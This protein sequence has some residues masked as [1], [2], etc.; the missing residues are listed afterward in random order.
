LADVAS[1]GF[2]VDSS[3][4]NTA[5]TALGKLAASAKPAEA[6]VKQLGGTHAAGISFMR[7]H[8]AEIHANSNAI[9]LNR[10]QVLEL[11]H[12]VRAAFDSLAS[13]ASPFRVLAQQG[14]EL[15]QALTSGQG[16]VAGSLK[17]VGNALTSMFTVSRI[18]SGGLVGIATAGYAAW[19]AWDDKVRALTQSMNGLGRA[20]GLS[21]GAVMAMAQGGR[22][23]SVSQSMSSAG[24]YIGAGIDGQTT[25]RLMG[26]T[27]QYAHAFGLSTSD[28]TTELSKAFADPAKGLEELA[29][30]FGPLGAETD[31][32]VKRMAALGDLEGARTKLYSAYSVELEKTKDASG[33]LAKAMES[34]AKIASNAWARLG[35]AGAPQTPDEQVRMALHQLKDANKTFGELGNAN[36]GSGFAMPGIKGGLGG[37][38][39]FDMQSQIEQMAAQTLASAKPDTS[40]AD[41]SYF[42]TLGEVFSKISAGLREDAA[43]VEDAAKKRKSY[44]DLQIKEVNDNAKIGASAILARTAADRLAVDQ[45]RIRVAAIY[46]TSKANTA[47]A[48][49]QKAYTLAVAESQ[50]KLRDLT[51]QISDQ[52]RGIGG[53]AVER[54][55]VENDIW[56]RNTNRDLLGGA[57][58][59]PLGSTSPTIGG[60]SPM[61]ILEAQRGKGAGEIQGFLAS[62]GQNLNA[63]LLAWCAAALNSALQQAGIAGSGS[64]MARSLLKV[65]TPVTTP[66]RG[67]VVVMSRGPAGSGQGHTG[68]YDSTNEDG[69]IRVLGGNT[70]GRVGYGNYNPSSVLGYR[71]LGEGAPPLTIGGGAVGADAADLGAKR[72][73]NT[74][75]EMWLPSFN[76]AERALEGNKRMLDTQVR[77]FG[78]STEEIA[79]LTEAQKLEN[80]VKSKGLEVTD[81]MREKIGAMSRAQ[82]EFAAR[83]EAVDRIQRKAV[84]FSDLI[85]S[86]SND[87]ISSPLLA[88]AH[89]QKPGEAL[90]AAGARLG[91]N[92]IGM[93]TKSLTEG[94]F[95]PMG[96]SL[97]GIGGGDK[98][99]TAATVNVSGA[100]VNMGSGLGGALG[101]AATGGGAGGGPLG[102]IGSWFSSLFGG[103]AT[104]HAMGGVFGGRGS[105]ALKR[106][107][108]GGIA[109]SPQVAVFGEG[110]SPEAYVPLPDGRSIPVNMRGQVGGGTSTVIHAGDTHIQ[111]DGSADERTLRLMQGMVNTSRARTVSDIQRNLGSMNQSYQARHG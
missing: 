43:A 100:L 79:R 24:T 18:A 57:R 8:T 29:K 1:L 25:S 4:L 83:Q 3:Q 20:S 61:A 81:A 10:N 42:K 64:N 52:G 27:Q 23:M 7:G 50:K 99:I 34:T 51:E 31:M 92:L 74:M 80:E 33:V 75:K 32:Q 39:G 49:S 58:A 104:A 89:H 30:R 73:A 62:G 85:R 88:I 6:A 45:E 60:S 110:S 91:D 15:T 97:F 69:T 63:S 56:I 17:A 35:Q 19:S 36:V 105:V 54:A 66:Q 106:Y 14:G 16:G 5:T 93:G 78:M 55:K 48:E 101:G 41:A 102:A 77:T 109:N 98:D 90:A 95:G 84:E 59:N 68:F 37:K 70:G 11:T 44:L 72:L 67:D 71:R 82:G 38:P 76:D 21:A 40:A 87:L 103:G 86:T 2:S 111:V 94:I 12:V 96:K 13:G 46:D 26:S 107:A 28:A 9:A 65:G 22:G 108:G 47:A 53:T